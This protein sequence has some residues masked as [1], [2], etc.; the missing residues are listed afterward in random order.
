MTEAEWAL[1]AMNALRAEVN[2]KYWAAVSHITDPIAKLAALEPM[3]GK[4]DRKVYGKFIAANPRPMAVA[5]TPVA[6]TPVVPPAKTPEEIAAERAAKID[7][8]KARARYEAENMLK[9]EGVTNIAPYMAM[10]DAELGRAEGFLGPEDD[11]T[12]FINGDLMANILGGERAKTTGQWK[13]EVATNFGPGFEDK[14][15]TSSLLDDVITDILGSQRGNALTYLDRGKARGIYNDVGY[16][17]GMK[18][19]EDAM[20]AGK[21]ELGSLGNTVLDKYRD[22]ADRVGDEAYDYVSSLDF[23]DSFSLEPYLSEFSGIVSRATENAGGDLRGLLGGRNFFD[24]SNLSGKAGMA[25]GALNLRDADV[26]TALAE[27]RRKNSISRG[28]GSVGAF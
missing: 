13:K 26:A 8:A 19:L 5:P 4:V 1:A 16:S 21:S 2:P 23:D 9:M 15:I 11:P 6:P 24:F 27:R 20:S 18:A 28:L 22:M 10:F 3:M 17:A 7:R 14:A 12:E 25:Q